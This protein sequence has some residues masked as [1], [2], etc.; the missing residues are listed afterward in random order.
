[1]FGLD[2]CLIIGGICGKFGESRGIF[3]GK[4]GMFLWLR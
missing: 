4:C 2:R 3:P 1:M